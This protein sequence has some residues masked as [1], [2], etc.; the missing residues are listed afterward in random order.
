MGLS[1]SQWDD[2]DEHDRAWAL[3]LEYAD[4][5][6]EARRCRSCGGDPGECQDADNQH[7]Y[8][9]STRRCYK[10]AAISEAQKKRTDHD[11]VQFVA[12]LDP[13]LKKSVRRKG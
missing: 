2:L 4:E 9:V 3:A 5:V 1:M 8:V 6:A 11:G 12:V 10:T 13:T 7:A